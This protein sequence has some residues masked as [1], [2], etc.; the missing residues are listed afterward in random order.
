MEKFVIEKDISA[1]CVQATSFPKD[2]SG[3]FSTLIA[4][5]AGDSDR[6]LYGISHPAANGVII[7]RAAA[8][9]AYH[10]EGKE[11]DLET[12]VIRDGTYISIFLEDWKKDEMNIGRSFSKLLTYPGIDPNG[13]CLEI[14][15]GDDVRCLVPLA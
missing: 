13:Y 12:F 5:L 4:K 6:Q 11:K 15:S 10:G 7:Y 9:E 14:Y 3:A 1:L 2:V 8:K